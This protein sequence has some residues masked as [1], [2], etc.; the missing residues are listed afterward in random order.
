MV[1]GE[2]PVR[3]LTR[4]VLE[5]AAYQVVEAASGRE[6]LSLWK[7][8][9]ADFHLLR[10]DMVMPDRLSGRDLAEQLR[11]QPP[12]LK[13]IFMSG[14]SADVAGKDTDFI[15]RTKSRFLQKP[16]S[17]NVLLQAVRDSLDQS[18]AQIFAQMRRSFSK[19]R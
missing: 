17:A 10:T 6:A 18:P 9:S 16:C 3:V 5:N 13:V 7:D 19:R 8:R 14:Y 4:R 2:L 15:R 11:S 1:E 12:A